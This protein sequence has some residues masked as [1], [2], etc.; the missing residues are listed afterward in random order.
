MFFSGGFGFAGAGK[1]KPAA[2]ETI[3][4][5]WN[6]TGTGWTATNGSDQTIDIKWLNQNDKTSTEA[7]GDVNITG[8][9]GTDDIIALCTMNGSITLTL[10]APLE[11]STLFVFGSN[12]CTIDLNG[13]SLK[14]NDTLFLGSSWS[15]DGDNDID[16]GIINND[17]GGQDG[18]G[19]KLGN[20]SITTD[21]TGKIS[22][23]NFNTTTW[24]YSDDALVFKNESGTVNSLLTI[25]ENVTFE[26]ETWETGS[27]T[28]PGTGNAVTTG[29]TIP[30]ITIPEN[31]TTSIEISKITSDVG[32]ESLKDELVKD[33]I[34]TGAEIAVPYLWT[35]KGSDKSWNTKENW[36]N[37]TTPSGNVTAYI[38]KITNQPEIVIPVDFSGGKIEIYD[39]AKLTIADGGSL[40]IDANNIT[41]GTGSS[42]VVDGTLNS[43]KGFT[44]KSNFA[45]S[46]GTFSCSDSGKLIIDTDF[47]GL[48][49]L[50]NSNGTI[51][52]NSGKNVTCNSI[53][54]ATLENN[55]NLTLK[56]DSS[57][58]NLSNN[59][60][61][62][63][64]SDQ[65]ISVSGSNV[66]LGNISGTIELIGSTDLWYLNLSNTSAGVDTIIV[67]KEKDENDNDKNVKF[68]KWQTQTSKIKNVVVKNGI[69]TF[70]TPIEIENFSTS[71][72]AGN[73]TF[74]KNTT[75][76]NA[77]EINSKNTVS[78][79]SDE[80]STTIFGTEENPVNFTHTA[81]Q[82]NI[83]GSLTANDIKCE[84]TT[85]TGNVTAKKITLAEN[86]IDGII[87]GTEITLGKTKLK[88]NITGTE[89]EIGDVELNG[90]IIGNNIT[91][92]EINV[93]GNS[94]LKINEAATSGKI[95]LKGNVTS[96]DL[97]NLTLNGNVDVDVLCSSINL[98]QGT[99]ESNWTF[100]AQNDLE[101]NAVSTFEKF[102]NADGNLT[103]N[104][105]STFNQTVEVGKNLVITGEVVFKDAVKSGEN[106]KITGNATFE[107]TEKSVEV[108]NDLE[109]IGNANFANTV[110][111]GNNLT[112]EGDEII[113]NGAAIAG[114]SE[115]FTEGSILLTGTTKITVNSLSATKDITVNGTTIKT[116]A[117][118][119]TE[120]I[121]INKGFEVLE[122]TLKIT[123]DVVANNFE[124]VAKTQT[125]D[126]TISVTNLKITGNATFENTE[127][128]VEIGN[129]LRIVGNAI[130]ANTVATGNNLTI[131]GN[132]VFENTVTT[133]N[134]LTI[135]GNSKFSQNVVV[136]NVATLQGNVE[137]WG[138]L[139]I[140]QDTGYLLLNGSENQNVQL[141]A[142]DTYKKIVVEKTSGNVEI[143]NVATIEK[144]ENTT[145]GTTTF[146]AATTITNYT[147]KEGNTILK[148][149]SKITSYTNEIGKSTFE[150]DSEI[151]KLINKDTLEFGA[152]ITSTESVE[153][154][155]IIT[156]NGE[157]EIQAL[158][159][160]G[161]V[162]VNGS[163]KIST[164]KN[165]SETS[166]VQFNQTGAVEILENKGKVFVNENVSA[167]NVENEGKITIAEGKIFAISGTLTDKNEIGG[168]GTIK[169]NGTENQNV[170][171][172]TKENIGYKN[173]FV[174]KTS[175][176]VEINNSATI[177]NFENVTEGTTSFYAATII[178]NYTN[179]KGN[180]IF[181]EVAKISSYTNESGTTTF[182]K[183]VE[184]AKL[185]NKDNVKCDSK[186]TSSE[187]IENNGILTIGGESNINSL[188]NGGNATFEGKAT[189]T[190]IEN[191][192]TTT[193]N[194]ESEIQTL[195]NS[196]T[197]EINGSSKIT[198]LKNTAENAEIKINAGT[199]FELIENGG[200]VEINE[201]SITK[202]LK[203]TKKID[204]AEGKSLTILENIEDSGELGGTGALRFTGNAEQVI[205]LKEN[206]IYPHIVVDKDGGKITFTNAMTVGLFE[207][208]K[209]LE[210]VFE[211]KMI[212]TDLKIQNGT[213]NLFK[214]DV[215]ITSLRVA[216]ASETKFDLNVKVGTF[217]DN[218]D[219]GIYI[220]NK[221]ANFATETSINTTGTVSFGSDENSTTIFGTEDNPVNFMHTA[222]KTLITG[223]LSAND[224]T[225]GETSINGTVNANDINCGNTTITGNVTAKK[226]T[227]AENTIDGTVTGTEITLGKTTLNGNITGTE[228]EI[229]DVELNGSIIGNNITLAEILVVEDSELKINETSTDG[230]ITLNGNVLSTDSKDLTLN[231]NVDV[232]CSSINLNQ[233][234]L[235]SKGTFTAQND[236]EINAVSIF[237][238]NVDA[239]ENFTIN[240]ASKFIQTV[241]V[242]KNLIITGEVVF[243]DAVKSGENLNITGNA[244]FE[245]TEKSVEVRNDLEIFGNA[246]FANTVITGNNLTIEGD[247]IIINGAAIAGKSEPFTEGS[248]L[249]TSTTKITAN[250]LFATE[251]IFINK[252][253]EV[254]EQTL[255]IT[256][257]V[258]ANNFESVAKTQ[259]FGGTIS[260]ANDFISKGE[261]LNFANVVSVQ[262][263]FILDGET[264]IFADDIL[265]GNDFTSEGTLFD[266]AKT[267][268]VKNINLSGQKITFAD[269]VSVNRT[270]EIQNT[271]LLKIFD[272]VYGKSFVQKGIESEIGQVMIL[273]SFEQF[274]ENGE[275]EN[276][277]A[278]FGSN[279]YF[280]NSSQ[281]SLDITIGSDKSTTTIAGNLIVAK[282]KDDNIA[283]KGT[284]NSNNFALYSGNVDLSGS[285]ST[286]NDI[287]VL[288]EKY[289]L[290]DNQTGIE[291]LYSYTENRPEHWSKASYTF[292]TSLPD[293]TEISQNY[294]GTVKVLPE[295]S[296]TV[297]KNLYA[298]GTV[299]A[300]SGALGSGKWKLNVP[301]TS[302]AAKAFCEVY[303]SEVSDC[304]ASCSQNEKQIKIA[305]LQCTDNSGNQ[306]WAFDDE[307]GT[308]KI[309]KAYSVSDNVIRVELN[310]P[311]RILKDRFT[312][313]QM[314]FSKD[315]DENHYF[316]NVYLDEKCTEEA[317]EVVEQYYEENESK[318]YFVYVK[319]NS[320][321]NTDAT[322][323]F[324][325]EEKSTDYD[326]VHHN[327]TICLDF[328]RAIAT[329][330][331]AGEN[332]LSYIITDLWGKRL[333]NY[334]VRTT[335]GNQKTPFENVEDKTGPVL[336]SVKTGQENHAEYDGTKGA[337]SQPSYD[338]HNFI[339]FVYSEFVNFGSEPAENAAE[340]PD[341]AEEVF[342]KADD[343]G[344]KNAKNIQVTQKFGALQNEDIT[345]SGELKFSGLAKI[346]N[347]KIYTGSQKNQGKADKYVNA[348]YRFDKYS[349][350]YSIAGY[351]H[352]TEFV[353][354]AQ[355][356]NYKKW[357]GYIQEAELPSGTVSMICDGKND[358]VFDMA[359]NS[360][361]LVK[362]NLTVDSTKSG[363]YGN[364][365]ISKPMFATLR[366]N[367]TQPW[368]E[369]N[370]IEA[371]GNNKGFGDTLDRVEFHLFDN[372]PNFD[373]SDEAVWITERGWC[374]NIGSSNPAL[375]LND[376]YCADIFG[377]SRAFDSNKENRTAGGIRF[378]SL[379]DVSQAFMYTT[380]TDS[381]S[382]P[383]EKFDVSSDVVIGTNAR[384]FTGNSDVYREAKIIDGLYFSLLLNDKSLN[385]KTTFKISYD[386]NLGYITDLAGNRLKSKNAL[387]VDRTP[388][389]IE[390]ILS[391]IDN[392]NFYVIFTKKLN[393]S[394]I[395]LLDNARSEIQLS[396]SF[397]ELLPQCFELITINDNGTFENAGIQIDPSVVA[398]QVTILENENYT[399]FKMAFT[400]EVSL[401]DVKNVYLRVVNPKKYDY[402]MCDPITNIKDSY[403]TIIQDDFGNYIDMFQTHA[404][405]D[406]AINGINP[407]Y[408]YNSSIQEDKKPVSSTTQDDVSFV[409]RDWNENQQ[410]YGTLYHNEDITIVCDVDNTSKAENNF[411]G[412]VNLYFNNDTDNKMTSEQFNKKIGGNL[413]IW[414]P[415]IMDNHF[416]FFTYKNNKNYGIISSEQV[417]KDDISAGIKFDFSKSVV[418][419]WKS[420]NQISYLFSYLNEDNSQ[421]NIYPSPKFNLLTGLYELNNS[422]K[423]PLFAIRMKDVNDIT[424]LDLWSFKVKSVTN[425]RG[426]VTIL[427]NVIN[428]TYGE[429]AIVKINLPQDGNLDVMVMTLD[430]NIVTYLNHGATTS[431]EHY[432]T[433]NGTNNAGSKVARGLYFVRVIS[434]TIDET[435]KI[436]VVKD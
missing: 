205:T 413:R 394:K 133:G 158:E 289:S 432:F 345:Q 259:T 34:D 157:A 241:E 19:S 306:N 52:I 365:D 264:F 435:R 236:L 11:I 189:I 183:D 79:G 285:L 375:I 35:G 18:E 132:A 105:D 159:N 17:A 387:T 254:L 329:T 209:S 218:A 145:E 392:K 400:R 46:T 294:A 278:S 314:R 265:V 135:T 244:T 411:A 318:N 207:T 210:T 238:K 156:I 281:K 89:V 425:Q 299:F 71:E 154:N 50:E 196:G 130:F 138:T 146:N 66:T 321:W 311:V 338:S 367:E 333:T 170:T 14:I 409:V 93:V 243:K 82:T 291:N 192:G 337:E 40:S 219:S 3:N 379:E 12:V 303:N 142:N 304:D 26:V 169:I 20:L 215:E 122:Q 90:S 151:A 433:W 150:K 308:V 312:Q 2:G 177:E 114:K 113:I 273:G 70:D 360:Q 292:E 231:G 248:I 245:S 309:T 369:S 172:T 197:V 44:V 313:K 128:S 377:G 100:T 350:R 72:N 48:K 416:D 270:A 354:D 380:K 335:L 95:T 99:L 10:N 214:N 25:G 8:P 1:I 267:V 171:L 389:L 78:F 279:V 116:A 422:M 371:I 27:T 41:F 39:D 106:L 388:P 283:I 45:G 111:T 277:T 341:G 334:S 328:P 237:E 373:F 418:E 420:G 272:F 174:E 234:T 31:S 249:L 229:G 305:A 378:S 63:I 406:V 51:T 302:V 7:G 370:Y 83:K 266:F 167:K 434:S 376:A 247:E 195:E 125:F 184:I 56:D 33:L 188:Q 296:I 408:G 101:I 399:A 397:L 123:G 23:T 68:T 412:K 103:I 393:L 37:N 349:L 74:S 162:E 233:G 160:S 357:I 253:S 118:I 86:T 421:V 355:G 110:T 381:D 269:K 143:Y 276:P 98:N 204:I 374:R 182:E 293:G 391:P 385:V 85:I 201:N 67:N 32:H 402:K 407:L 228:V 13:Y 298:N 198:T 29:A 64:A 232:L 22:I 262:N 203:N 351:T 362:N 342:L 430:G 240:G 80:N 417:D 436:M 323:T 239:K 364:W 134:N 140:T 206:A 222:G 152:K 327:T 260:V 356:N 297:G 426:G 147:N 15:N 287:V 410:N 224:V 315:P 398:E 347:G 61:I 109:I 165:I 368:K 242:G 185:I 339:E 405:S 423:F 119:A 36:T 280:Y 139:S 60:T 390:A 178:S 307:T 226:I 124:A 173:I 366:M 427:N 295:K 131:T 288:G 57:I 216:T 43:T 24:G 136:E 92:A 326:G 4:L 261:C 322:G 102:V 382:I 246:N 6:G 112:I 120:N 5:V 30:K 274:E 346:Q 286:V 396:E 21:S 28:T 62:T 164:L 168:D 49:K 187:S 282:S 348:L 221:N 84:N 428:A 217:A 121:F 415:N 97:K 235:E 127:K 55:G 53:S 129:D 358:L 211:N 73:I 193:T 383:S 180:S 404:I 352:P 9:D 429:K 186:F 257:D 212:F 148:D 65:K 343:Q 213:K 310:K 179:T 96:T 38:C 275:S 76:K 361:T 202:S 153:N 324:V 194:S 271:G 401:E 144:F 59:G 317:S 225:L 344:I 353:Q 155:G 372:T 126:G 359:G 386:E 115:P 227:I 47:A 75:I 88:G 251:N 340:N 403:V 108:G 91:L 384:L 81:G 69:T 363:V 331:G 107:S 320:K 94:E 325:G 284:V 250:S 58:G 395:V 191:T 223:T 117:L 263:D 141:N 200:L 181:K 54:A 300:L 255:N 199:T 424:S 332:L 149:V 431:G 77:C 256:G 16:K 301:D 336:I 42:I 175:G 230:K 220:F 87:T 258:S 190:S 176:N 161:T 419:N 319:A 166:E 330:T 163:S 137:F 290:K 208:E 414:F 316:E 252:D 104:G 268:T